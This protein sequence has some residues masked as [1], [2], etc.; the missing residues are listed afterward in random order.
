MTI[1][2]DYRTKTLAMFGDRVNEVRIRA[3]VKLNI[4]LFA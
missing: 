1:T 3:T 4:L 2:L